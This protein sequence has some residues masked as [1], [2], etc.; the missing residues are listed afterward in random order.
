MPNWGCGACNWGHQSVKWKHPCSYKNKNK[1]FYSAPNH[2]AAD[3]PMKP[4]RKINKKGLYPGKRKD[5]LKYRIIPH[6]KEH[7]FICGN[8]GYWVNK[9]PQK[10][11]N[12]NL[13][14]FLKIV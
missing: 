6:K 11:I 8:K 14:P 5:Y 9:C 2:F 10:N 13:Q 7:C 3:K 4:F 12:P 1:K